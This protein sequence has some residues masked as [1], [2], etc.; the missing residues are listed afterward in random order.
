MYVCIK[1]CKFLVEIWKLGDCVK[2][3]FIICILKS[4]LL[5]F[6][7]VFVKLR[8]IEVFFVFVIV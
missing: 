4:I 3:V 2:I 7:G 5:K 6:E 1:I 8:L